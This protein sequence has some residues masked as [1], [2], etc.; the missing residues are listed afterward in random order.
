MLP[1]NMLLKPLNQVIDGYNDKI[2]VNTSGHAL[3]KISLPEVAERHLKVQQPEYSHPNQ[4]KNY[5]VNYQTY[6]KP[7][8]VHNDEKTALI[9]GLTGL[10]LFV[11][12]WVK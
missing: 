4:T 9:L 12:W 5:H 8:D 3:G 1:S 10:T 6:V 2:V 7:L 11:I